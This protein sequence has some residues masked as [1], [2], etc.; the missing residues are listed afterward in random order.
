[1]SQIFKKGH[2]EESQLK[3]IIMLRGEPTAEKYYYCK[4]LER[5][6]VTLVEA[7]A[8]SVILEAAIVGVATLNVAEVGAVTALTAVRIIKNVK[9]A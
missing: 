7:K 5:K 3:I 6:E 1:M 2:Q 8:G 9:G 4:E